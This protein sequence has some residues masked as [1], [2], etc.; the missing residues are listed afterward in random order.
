MNIKVETILKEDSIRK[1][2]LFKKVPTNSTTGTVMPSSGIAVKTVSFAPR[3][4]F[5]AGQ[6]NN[7][8]WTVYTYTKDKNHLAKAVT[9]VKRGLEFAETPALMDTYARLL[10]KTGNKEEAINWEQKAIDGN[11]KRDMSAVEFEKV[12]GLMKAGAEKIDAY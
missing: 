5:Y 8:A 11:K 9:W 3:A 2:N 12:L 10:Y 7:G 1:E 4:G 6:L